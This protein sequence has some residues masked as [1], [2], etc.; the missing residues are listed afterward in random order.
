MRLLPPD[1]TRSMAADESLH[2]EEDALALAQTPTPFGIYNIKLMKCGGV[3]SALG[4]AGIAEAA[5]IRLMWGCM[6]ESV[7]SIAA[8]LHTAYA[9]PVTRYLD[10][11]GSFDLAADLASGGFVLRDGYLHVL[12]EP[13]LGVRLG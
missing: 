4:I 10:L 13:G 9:C 5:G 6:D 11:D 7:I 8:A 1:V 3:T 2:A 12:D